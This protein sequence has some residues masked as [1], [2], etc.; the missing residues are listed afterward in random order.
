MPSQY[1]V[2]KGMIV[3]TRAERDF[4]KTHYILEAKGENG[5]KYTVPINVRSTDVSKPDLLYY[6]SD[7]Y[8]AS[9]ITILPE[10]EPGFHKIDY[11]NG[12][13]AEIAVDF[14]RSGLFNPNEM[15]IVPYDQPGPDNDLNDFID[16]N[17]KLALDNPNATV[18]VYGTLFNRTGIHNVHMNQGN[19]R[20]AAQENGTYHDGCVLIQFK[21]NWVAY[22]LA[23]QTQSWCTDDDGKPD[24]NNLEN[25]VPTGSCTFDKVKHIKPLQLH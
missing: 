6:V 24:P 21:D 7:Q 4:D 19:S 5:R 14:I 22:F 11:H 13:N 18:Y 1:G 2:L 8:D 10:L 12:V 16:K 15:L 9:A 3:G 23:F 20:I 17:M 25:G